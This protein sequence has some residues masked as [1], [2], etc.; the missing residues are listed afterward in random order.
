MCLCPLICLAFNFEHKTK[1]LYNKSIISG[2]RFP[3]GIR[4]FIFAIANPFSNPNC[5]GGGGCSFPEVSR[6]EHESDRSLSPN[7]LIDSYYKI[8]LVRTFILKRIT[9]VWLIIR[10]LSRTKT[11]NCG[12]KQNKR[13]QHLSVSSSYC[14]LRCASCVRFLCLIIIA[15]CYVAISCNVICSPMLT[16]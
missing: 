3:E 13:T 6:P 5:T 10:N 4:S 14:L 11:S 8:S 12:R 9:S 15:C 7:I 16:A 1:L 2:V